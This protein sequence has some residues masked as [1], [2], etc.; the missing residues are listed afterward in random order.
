MTRPEMEKATVV[1][2]PTAWPA[3]SGAG[4][5]RFEEYVAR[6]RVVFQRADQFLRFRAYARGLLEPCDRK[7]VEAVAAAA[8]RV[9]TVEAN[10]AQ[11]L[12][13]FVSHSPWDA[14]R[15]FATV[16]SHTAPHR[17]DRAA[18]WVVHDGVFAK[19][20]RHSVGV[21]RQFARALQRKINCQIGV[22]VSQ[23]GPAGYFPLAARLYLPASWLRDNGNEAAIPA[24]ERARTTKT[25]IALRLLDE[26]RAE[27]AARAVTGEPGYLDDTDFR[28]GLTARELAAQDDS[29]AS[30]AEALRR[31]EW[32]KG[33]LGLDHFEGRTWHGWHHHVG[34]VF[35]AYGF[36]CGEATT[37]D[38][39]PFRSPPPSPL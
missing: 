22:F 24:A 15:L 36:L 7:N 27:G 34:L 9:I 11:A 18:L 4:L 32:L 30:V 14:G 20:G 25:Q 23:V 33:E 37:G 31:F 2:R 28:E 16:R 29:P 3:L 21:Q 12:Q 26:L 10:L 1:P 5:A 19:K 35:A 39:P 38:L 13:H 17:D 6:F 8:G